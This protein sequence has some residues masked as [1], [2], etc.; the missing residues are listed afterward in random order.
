MDHKF[1]TRLLRRRKEEDWLEF[2]SQLRLYDAGENL[3]RQQR[4]ELL[5]DLIGLANGN[6]R[7]I[8]RTKYLIVGADDQACDQGGVRILHTV[9]Y[10][11]PSQSQLAQWLSTVCSPAIVGIE[12][13]EVAF[14]NNRLLVI[15]VPPTFELH[16]TTQPLL[17]RGRFNKHTVFMRQDEHTVTASVRDGIGIQELKHLHRHQVRNPSVIWLGA[18]IGALSALGAREVSVNASRS[19]LFVPEDLFLVLLGGIGAFSGASIG[20]IASELRLRS[21]EWRF[22]TKWERVAFSLMVII[23]LVLCILW[24]R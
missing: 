14:R 15:S 8:R 9:D 7:I 6:S 22:M 24:I 12:C 5:K 19:D 11:T 20:F 1:L 18:V 10:K 21:Y 4:D 16:E 3:I 2:K 23:A 13:E 17:A